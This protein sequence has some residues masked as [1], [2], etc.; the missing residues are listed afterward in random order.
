ELSRAAF[1]RGALG[2]EDALPAT[3]HDVLSARIDTLSQPAR[4]VVQAAAVL[5]REVSHRLLEAVSDQPEALADTV[6]ELT[7]REFLYEYP[8]GADR[9][10]VFRHGLVQEVAY[11]TLLEQRRAV[12]HGRAARTLE[13]FYDRRTDEVV[14]LLAHHFGRSGDAEKA[15][16][17]AILAGE[18]A[19][20]RWANAEG[21]A[22][23]GAALARLDAL[24]ESPA[25]SLRR[26]DAV[27]RQGEVRFAVGQHVE[28]RTLLEQIGPLVER[29]ADPPRRA[30][31]HYWTGFLYTMTGG[32]PELVIEHCGRAVAIAESGGLIELRAF[33]ESCLAQVYV[34][35]GELGRAVETGERALDT[36]ET[37]GNR[38]WAGRTLSHLAAAA[39]ALG[40]WDKALGYCHRALGHG[41]AVD[42]LRLKVSAL[43]RLGLTHIQRGEVAEGLRRC[44]E[45][46]ALSPTPYDAAALRGIRAYGLVMAGR[47]A[48]AIAELTD[49]LDWYARSNLHFTRY[50]FMLWLGEAHLRAGALEAAR[51]TAEEVLTASA[52]MGYR[53]LEAV[54]RRLLGESLLGVDPAAASRHLGDA[55]EAFRRSGARDHLARSL[56]SQAALRH[57]RGEEARAIAAL[58]EGLT[59]FREIGTLDEP[60][61][62]GEALAL[63]GAGSSAAGHVHHH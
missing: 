12:L 50:Q 8:R 5:G 34:F 10:Y 59:I 11:A 60:A 57:M 3:I 6:R 43:L 27:L 36:F 44:E 14:E 51:K 21:L 9:V 33:A 13:A 28:Q 49:V 37:L 39:N 17:Y 22:H 55:I 38:W 19:Q 61:R 7:R 40:H 58:E 29:A 32:R 52:E 26:I 42:D 41:L 16:D 20:R 1:E 18:K 30:A 62:V 56:I 24:P 23:F 63:L 47:V 25:N 31:W 46:Q 4:R 15:V 54:A 48:E 45:A 53:H 2:A 35:A